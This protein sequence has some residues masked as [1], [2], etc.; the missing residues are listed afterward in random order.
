MKPPNSYLADC[1][2]YKLVDKV[3]SSYY[4]TVYKAVYSHVDDRDD[5]VFIKIFD[6]NQKDDMYPLD[7][8]LKEIFQAKKCCQH[9]NILR[10]VH[11]SFKKENLLCVVMPYS[12]KPLPSLAIF[13][14]GLPEEVVAFVI[15]ETLKA[16]DCIHQSGDR[17]HG[18]LCST[19]MFLD[20][21][22]NV[23]LEFPTWLTK[24]EMV[25]YP[26]SNKK[27][28]KGDFSMV[29]TLAY[30]LFNGTGPVEKRLPEYLEDFVRFCGSSAGGP[31]TIQEVMS[32]QFL[33]KFCHF[34]RYKKDLKKLLTRKLR[35]RISS[36]FVCIS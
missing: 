4:S 29:R 30:D 21:E 17:V 20:E 5:N 18:N 3:A 26:A 25:E 22:A 9:P 16:L 1:K 36:L 7:P 27:N 35:P 28:K 6:L 23:K 24:A 34:D 8:I 19:E 14:H 33:K 12:N 15:L 11:C 2:A 32:H 31:V 10:S 13:K